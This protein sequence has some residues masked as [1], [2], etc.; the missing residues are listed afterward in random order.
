MLVSLALGLEEIPRD[1]GGKTLEGMG[2]GYRGIYR[3]KRKLAKKK[4][5]SNWGDNSVYKVLATQEGRPDLNP[6]SLRKTHLFP[7]LRGGE[8]GLLELGDPRILLRGPVSKHKMGSPWGTIPVDGLCFPHTF[9]HTHERAHI[10]IQKT[11]VHTYVNVNTHKGSP[12][13]D[14]MLLVA[15]NMEATA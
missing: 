15:A 12:E 6:Q 5:S 4:K 3:H 1:H 7:E 8:G 9:A 2:V 14:E 10:S 11:H 13:P